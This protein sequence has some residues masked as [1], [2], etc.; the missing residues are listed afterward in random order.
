MVLSCLSFSL[1]PSFGLS[2]SIRHFIPIFRGSRSHY[3]SFTPGLCQVLVVATAP[4]ECGMVFPAARELPS[5]QTPQVKF[6][7]N[8]PNYRWL[9]LLPA[10]VQ[11]VHYRSSLR[12]WSSW[13]PNCWNGPHLVLISHKRSH[14][15]NYERKMAVKPWKRE[16]EV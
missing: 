15:L 5:Q 4:E 10:S 2:T 12:T 1:C 3:L 8:R 11:C 7:I 16:R 14:F 6:Y 13:G 9:S